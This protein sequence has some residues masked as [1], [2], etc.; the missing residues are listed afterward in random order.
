MCA[1][2]RLAH[3]RACVCIII[4]NNIPNIRGYQKVEIMKK[5][6]RKNIGKRIPLTFDK[7]HIVLE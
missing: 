1:L 2:G 4:T 3:Q 7:R 5:R 6:N